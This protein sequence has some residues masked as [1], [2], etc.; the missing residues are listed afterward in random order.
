M[1]Y[2][3]TKA[4]TNLRSEPRKTQASE[5]TNVL[6]VMPTNHWFLGTKVVG[7]WVEGYTTVN[8][9]NYEGFAHTNL[10]RTEKI[11]EGEGASDSSRGEKS[12]RHDI[13]FEEQAEKLRPFLSIN[14]PQDRARAT[15]AL[16]F[17]RSRVIDI[18]WQYVFSPKLV[19]DY[20]T[21]EPAPSKTFELT[22]QLNYF[23]NYFDEL[24]GISP[25]N[26]E[27]RKAEF[28]KQATIKIPSV[29]RDENGKTVFSME[30][31][32]NLWVLKHPLVNRWFYIEPIA[33]QDAISEADFADYPTYLKIWTERA[34]SVEV[35][36][37]DTEDDSIADKLL[38]AIDEIDLAPSIILRQYQELQD[39][40]PFAK[41]LSDKA[42]ELATSQV[43]GLLTD[44]QINQLLN[45]ILRMKQPQRDVTFSER[46]LVDRA[47]DLNYILP[48][49]NRTYKYV[50]GST[51][52]MVPG[53]LYQPYRTTIYWRSQVKRVRYVTRTKKVFGVVVSRRRVRQEWMETVNNSRRVT[54]YGEVQVDLDPWEEKEVELAE[55]EGLE[56]YRF[57][58]IN[59]DYFDVNGTSL[60]SVIENCDRNEEFRRKTAIWIPVYEQKLTEGEILTKYTIIKRPFRGYA[61]VR[62][63]AVFVHEALSYRTAWRSSELGELVH[64]INMGPGEERTITVEQTTSRQ[65]ETVQSTTSILDLTRSDTLELSSEIEREAGNSSES[66]RTSTFSASASGSIGAFGGS[67]S[68]STSS[69]KTAKQFSRQMEKVARKAAR[70]LTRRSHQEVKSTTTVTT[71]AS[72]SEST[73]INVKNVNEGRT[74]NLLFYRLYN[75]FDASLTAESLQFVSEDGIEL[76]SGSGITI[77]KVFELSDMDQALSPFDLSNLPYQTAATPGSEEYAKLFVS[78]WSYIIDQILNLLKKEYDV[79]GAEASAKVIRVSNALSEIMNEATTVGGKAPYIVLGDGE[80]KYTLENLYAKLQEA[81]EKI[82]EQLEKSVDDALDENE[83]LLPLLSHDLRV[84]SPGLYVDTVMG[85]SPATEPY[86]EEMRAQKVLMEAAEVAKQGAIADYYRV[87]SGQEPLGSGGRDQPQILYAYAKSDQEIVIQLREFVTSGRWKLE[88]DAKEVTSFDIAEDQQT[89]EHDCGEAQ[90]WL[91]EPEGRLINIRKGRTFILINLNMEG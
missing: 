3:R 65:I 55:K 77:P 11:I 40:K 2:F 49:T 25:G 48:L 29:S 80:D 27:E 35:S 75:I 16:S 17:N 37:S 60:E 50:D 36:F 33:G 34:D 12:K 19:K 21:D 24:W 46:Q 31:K 91:A 18:D 73:S 90:E 8:G 22:D 5:P 82:I 89:V 69:T 63:P 66:T 64:S 15:E 86:A 58:R 9:K 30:K 43:T 62:S 51:E 68:G 26:F 74:L 32:E 42:N 53:K 78:Y 45:A 61:P 13:F 38:P 54:K 57:E 71:K 10:L 81:I 1:I 56:S 6:V 70:N 41:T 47:S 14:P 52:E 28:L 7:E 79:G 20:H 85:V 59:G 4:N 72:R 67:A 83:P 39:L 23:Q 76:V 88:V 87:L 84:A 44:N